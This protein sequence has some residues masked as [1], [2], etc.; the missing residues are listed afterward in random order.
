MWF[1]NLVG[2]VLQFHVQFSCR[3]QHVVSQLC[4]SHYSVLNTYISFCKT[5]KVT[6]PHIVMVSSTTRTGNSVSLDTFQHWR[7]ESTFG[8]KTFKDSK[9][10]TMV[11]F[12]WFK[13]YE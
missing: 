2:L 8:Y 6:Q 3:L 10:Q 4:I 7:K 1:L 11:N 13:L 5:G 9:G 12:I